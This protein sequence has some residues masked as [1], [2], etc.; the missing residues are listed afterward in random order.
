MLN[1]IWEFFNLIKYFN[2]L[3]SH[4]YFNYF[5]TLII[6]VLCYFDDIKSIKNAIFCYSIKITFMIFGIY[7]SY[8][9]LIEEFTNENI[10]FYNIIF[11][12]GNILFL[13]RSVLG[14]FT[15]ILLLK[16]I[17]NSAKFLFIFLYNFFCDINVKCNKTILIIKYINEKKS[18]LELKK[19]N[20][21]LLWFKLNK[22]KFSIY[23]FT[24]KYMII[25][26]VDKNSKSNQNSQEMILKS[27]SQNTKI[28]ESSN[29]KF[30]KYW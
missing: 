28:T 4:D 16:L 9:N 1:E 2:Y 11:Y 25:S 18:T 29:S 10:N 19:L 27:K 7:T 24:K 3:I 8:F 6:F 23:N 15:I 5:S 26:D 14:N 13:F 17:F 30:K 21:F 22:T 20:C 12:L